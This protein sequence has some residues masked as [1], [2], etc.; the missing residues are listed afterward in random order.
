MWKVAAT[1]ALSI[2][3]T[4]TMFFV[5]YGMSYLI[6]TKTID[7]IRKIKSKIKESKNEDDQRKK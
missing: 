4:C 5:I 1:V 3:L 7:L 6:V 2:F